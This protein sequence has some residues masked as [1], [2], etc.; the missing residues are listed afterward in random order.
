VDGQALPYSAAMDPSLLW[1]DFDEAW[2]LYEDDALI[3]V[4]KPAGIPSQAADP[5]RP[6]DVVTRLRAFL[7][8]RGDDP[9]LGV[10][11]RLDKDTSGVLVMTRQRDVNAPVAAQFEGRKVDKRYRAAVTGW[12]R[13]GEVELRDWL[14]PGDG[15]RTRVARKGERGADLAVARVREVSRVADRSVLE[16]RLET[17]RTHQARVQ[18]ANVGAPIAGDRLYG[19]S[20][21][22]RLMLHASEISLL[23]P[24][25]NKPLRVQ[26]KAPP[27]LDAWLA[28]G[29]AG[30]RVYDDADALGRTL[31]GAVRTRYALGHTHEGNATTAFRLVHDAGDALP[32]L[33]VDVYGDWLVAELHADDPE[34][35]G[36]EVR[37]NRVLDALGSL[38]AEGVYLKVR[39]K[40]SS[41]LVDTRREDLA[42]KL[43]VRGAEAPFEIE[44]LESGVPFGVRLGDGLP[45]GL[46]LDQRNNRLRVREA[47]KGARVANLFA[48]TCA[49]SVAAA[50]GGAKETVSVDAAAT[51]LERGRANFERAGIACGTVHTFVA[52]DVFAWIARARRK[53]ETYD[54]VIVDPP[55]YSST[56]KRR[57]V[58]KTDYTELAA[59]AMALVGRGGSLLACANHRGITKGRFRKM[60]HDAARSAGREVVQAKDLPTPSDFPVPPGGESHLKAVW[61]KLG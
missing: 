53:G 18:L 8:A 41:V 2:I 38:G 17:G 34:L 1:P 46:F 59:E 31:A 25:T 13:K 19:G 40:Q 55:S 22:P 56:K 4:D 37:K 36:D 51:A 27:E 47:S 9:Y 3:A 45:T 26:A 48:Y 7:A 60:L 54:L 35:Y 52:E 33:V 57:F 11:Q 44:V 23:H 14:A 58:A 30:P 32:G 28:G 5:S 6:D 12:K 21:A 29:D 10:H 39:P 15:G 16:V 20:A 42:P 24:R 50:R 61:V 43:P 49:F